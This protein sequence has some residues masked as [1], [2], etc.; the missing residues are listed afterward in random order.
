MLYSIV[1]TTRAGRILDTQALLKK[2]DHSEFG[3][4]TACLSHALNAHDLCG[5]DM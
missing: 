5:D 4:P 2:W 3:A 1:T